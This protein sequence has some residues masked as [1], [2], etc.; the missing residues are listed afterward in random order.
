[1]VEF[2]LKDFMN[3]PYTI[4]AASI[5]YYPQKIQ[6]AVVLGALIILIVL[7]LITK[8]KAKY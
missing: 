3:E 7:F 5:V 1:V 6:Q 8:R 4:E 2:D